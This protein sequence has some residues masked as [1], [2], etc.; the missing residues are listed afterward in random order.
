MNMVLTVRT[1]HTPCHTLYF[2][3]VQRH[4]QARVCLFQLCPNCWRD[5]AL[6]R[7]PFL[8]VAHPKRFGLWLGLTRSILFHRE[9]A[10]LIEVVRLVYAVATAQAPQAIV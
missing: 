5:D 9:L 10:N 2:R 1:V 4:D 3:C 6:S 8:I 7:V